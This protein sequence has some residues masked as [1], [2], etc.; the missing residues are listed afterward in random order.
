VKKPHDND[1]GAPGL[2]EWHVKSTI[3]A[4]E[5]WCDP[6]RALDRVLGLLADANLQGADEYD[7][8]NEAEERKRSAL[9]ALQ[10]LA[11]AVTD[12]KRWRR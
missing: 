9:L 7:D 10:Q 11:T 6:A 5:T 3:E 12:G 8:D 2:S 4:A 1:D